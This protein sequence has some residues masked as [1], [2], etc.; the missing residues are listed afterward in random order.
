MNYFLKGKDGN[1]LNGMGDKKVW[2]LW[3]ELRV[4][5]DVE[6]IETPTG[7][8]PMYEDLA[9]LFKEQLG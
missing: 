7:M 6:A 8:I 2:I 4:N 1:Y 5:G 9:K 3:A